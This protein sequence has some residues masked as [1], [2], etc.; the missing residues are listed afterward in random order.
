MG[1]ADERRARQAQGRRRAAPKR[2]AR[3]KDKA[4]RR[5][6]HTPVPQLEDASR[7]VLRFLPARH[8]RLHRALPGRRRAR[9]QRGR[10]AA[11]QRL[12][13]QRRHDPRPHRRGQPRGRGTGQG[14][15][16]RPEDLRRRREQVLLHGLGNRLQ[17]H[18]PRTDQHPVRQGPAGWLDDHPA[19]RQELLPHPGP[20]RHAQ[21]EGN[22]HLAEG[23]P[24]A[25]QGRHPRG[26]HQH[27]LLRPQRVRHPGR[28][29]GVLPRRRERPHRRA[30]R[31]P[32]LAPPGAEPVRLGGRH[33]RRQEA[34]QGPLELHPGQHG[35]AG[36]AGLGRARGHEVPGTQ[37]P[38]GRARYGGP[39]RLPGG[40]GQQRAGEA[41]RH[42]GHGRRRRHG[43]GAGR[44]GRLDHQAQHRQEEAGAAG[45]RPS[46][47][48]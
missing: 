11:E 39:D 44:R 1:R 17:G 12:P 32:R 22:G 38:P 37:G 40:R 35:R 42:P 28:G 41:T 15:Q 27:Q 4:G 16:G 47:R 31:V 34:G 5:S 26:L 23:G 36:L 2:S 6:W 21:A 24:A 20:D 13:V 29:A 9:G 19:V 25:V 45:E 33:G 18:G 43:Q 48:S 3:G 7:H 10:G 14:A 8:G 46:R 30:G